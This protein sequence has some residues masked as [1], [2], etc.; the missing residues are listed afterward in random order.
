[1]TYKGSGL[2]S[3]SLAI[4][5]WERRYQ[6]ASG[7][8]IPNRLISLLGMILQYAGIFLDLAHLL[9]QLE[10]LGKSPYL[11]PHL[12]KEEQERWN[13]QCLLSLE[14]SVNVCNLLGLE[15]SRLYL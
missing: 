4:L 14:V 2:Q 1:M 10:I 5:L 3:C 12:S 13:E 9:R 11:P 15:M 6:S 7:E 8:R